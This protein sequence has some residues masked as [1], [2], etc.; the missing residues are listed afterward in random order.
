MCV[1]FNIDLEMKNVVVFIKMKYVWNIKLKVG[2][3]LNR[4]VVWFVGL[5]IIVCIIL[6]LGFFLI[7]SLVVVFVILE[8]CYF[9]F[10]VYFY[11]EIF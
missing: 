11:F 10:L 7:I 3:I 5:W 4:I 2:K 8:I 9:N 6:F 1:V